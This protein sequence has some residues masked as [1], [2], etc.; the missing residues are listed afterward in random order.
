MWI[1]SP[2]YTTVRR[3]IV[4]PLGYQSPA[5]GDSVPVPGSQEA[6]RVTPLPR[7]T[8]S[9]L[10]HV[11]RLFA[12]AISITRTRREADSE[13]RISQ[14]WG[15]RG[16]HQDEVLECLTT[17]ETRQVS[18]NNVEY[19]LTTTSTPTTLLNHPRSQMEGTSSNDH[20]EP[21]SVCSLAAFEGNEKAN[22]IHMPSIA[23]ACCF[24]RLRFG[25]Q[26]LVRDTSSVV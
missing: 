2:R 6:Q 19:R 1:E 16:L 21:S 23:C 26:L 25:G 9:R 24:R 13:C 14:W 20:T 11:P 17:E 5:L 3:R 22:D 18:P 8:A 15:H 10:S 7:V 4:S 12:S